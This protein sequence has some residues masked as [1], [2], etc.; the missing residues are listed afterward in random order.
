MKRRLSGTNLSSENNLPTFHPEASS[1]NVSKLFS[2]LNLVPDNLLFISA[3]QNVQGVLLL[4]NLNCI[5]VNTS[6]IHY[7]CTLPTS[8]SSSLQELTGWHLASS[9]A[10]THNCSNKKKQSNESPMNNVVTETT[11]MQSLKPP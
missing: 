6:V 9:T 7:I 5:H 4:H 3:Q 1:R 10:A 11:I 8:W 2:K